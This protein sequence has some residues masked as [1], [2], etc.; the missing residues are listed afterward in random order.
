[1]RR[2]TVIL[3]MSGAL[4]AGSV[5]VAAAS[6]VTAVGPAADLPAPTRTDPQ[7]TDFTTSGGELLRVRTGRHRDYDRVVFDIRGSRPGWAVRYVPRLTQDGSGLP[8]AIRGPAVLQVALVGAAAHDEQGRPT[9]R[10]PRT[11]TPELPTLRQVRLAGDFEGVTTFGLGLRDRV[12]FRVFALSNPTRVVVDVAHQPRVRFGT[13]P[14]SRTGTAPDVLVDRVRTGRHPG[15]DRLVFDIRGAARPTFA[16]RYTGRGSTI[17]VTFT[18]VGSPTS[19]PHAS[20]A[21]PSRIAVG[22]P[23][24]RTVTLTVVGAGLMRVTVNTAHRHGFRVLTLG[25]PTR[26]VLD[27]AH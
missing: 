24:L 2:T 23:A 16:A 3:T 8:V 27:I 5:G 26:V 20:Y 18:G 14:V 19:S 15:Y 11:L 9:L 7:V 25:S 22:L 1:M 17:E 6:T 12:G 4:L 21:G 10:T 13:A